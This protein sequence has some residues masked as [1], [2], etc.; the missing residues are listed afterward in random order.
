MRLV[1]TIGIDKPSLAHVPEAAGSGASRTRSVFM[2][3]EGVVE[4][5]I[6]ERNDLAPGST[7]RGPAVIHQSDSTTLLPTYAEARIDQSHN[8]VIT[9]DGVSA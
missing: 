7:F 2:P 3:D 6:Y 9:I 4:A 5:M 1:A 8:I